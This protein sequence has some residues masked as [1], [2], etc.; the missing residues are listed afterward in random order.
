MHLNR[1]EQIRQLLEKYEQQAC[2]QEELR[3]LH[4]WLNELA[5]AGNPLEFTGAKDKE[6]LKNK[7]KR[8]V[9]SS[10][11]VPATSVS[12]KGTPGPK[13]IMPWI[14]HASISAAVL[15]GVWWVTRVLNA[16]G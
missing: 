15:L 3:Q 13:G 14:R 11:T 8:A 12:G 7:L 5:G 4:E 6:A 2:T 9:F 16:P 10:L 1:E